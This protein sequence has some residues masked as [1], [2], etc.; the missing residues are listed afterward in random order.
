MEARQLHA[1]SMGPLSENHAQFPLRAA[2]SHGGLQK[3]H[4][5]ISYPVMTIRLSGD[6][7]LGW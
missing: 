7:G 1:L 3:T 6:I 2:S 4:H 5:I